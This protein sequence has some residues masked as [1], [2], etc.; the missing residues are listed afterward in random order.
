MRDHGPQIQRG[1]MIGHHSAQLFSEAQ[2]SPKGT[3]KPSPV[4]GVGLHV[5]QFL[6]NEFPNPCTPALVAKSTGQSHEAIKKW[7]QR[8]E[9]TWV[10]RTAPG[11]WYRARADPRLL[12]QIGL[13][14]LKVHAVQVALSPNG[15]RPPSIEGQ[16]DRDGTIRSSW[17]GH[18]LT[19]QPMNDGG[20]FISVRCSKD[21]M[22]VEKFGQLT[23]WLYGLAG[24][25][26]VKLK[27]CD[28]NIDTADH[29]LKMR[30]VESVELGDFHGATVKLYNK[31]VIQ[32][33]R[34]EACFHRLDLGMAEAAQI[35]NGLT[36]KP[37]EP[38]FPAFHG[39]GSEWRVNDFI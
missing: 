25:K 19:A 21:P 12:A 26:P 8:N 6:R 9:G 1:G 33:T 37:Q 16:R 29:I 18:K 27:S 11:G 39:P 17:Q 32:A 5:L 14:P 13:E 36:S 38:E 31:Q 23:A 10:V 2:M 15:G 24:G 7:L 3:K 30:G 22:T 4:R 35:L 20:L 34:L 28:L